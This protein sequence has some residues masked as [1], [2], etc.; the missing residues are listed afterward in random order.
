M[1]VAKLPYYA[2]VAWAALVTIGV[3]I[4]QNFFEYASVVGWCLIAG[5]ILGFYLL[6]IE[7]PTVECE[8]AGWVLS[9]TLAFIVFTG[10]EPMTQILWVISIL[11]LAYA[12]LMLA[13]DRNP[14][15]AAKMPR[16][17]RPFHSSRKTKANDPASTSAHL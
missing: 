6:T 8:W 10:V 5:S 4:G 15:F 12:G 17:L 16:L 11:A 9:P 1:F 2:F 7:A 14:D 13:C 3:L